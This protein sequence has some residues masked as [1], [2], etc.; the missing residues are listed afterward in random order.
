ML[1]G[2]AEIFGLTPERLF[3]LAVAESNL[4]RDLEADQRPFSFEQ[5]QPPVET[6]SGI[7]GDAF[8]SYAPSWLESLPLAGSHNHEPTRSRNDSVTGASL[9]IDT[10]ALLATPQLGFTNDDHPFNFD[11]VQQTGARGGITGE[12]SQSFF[13]TSFPAPNLDLLSATSLGESAGSQ[14]ARTEPAPHPN[15]PWAGVIADEN[16]RATALT[17]YSA[18]P[19][20]QS[21]FDRELLPSFREPIPAPPPFNFATGPTQGIEPRLPMAPTT[22]GP[23]LPPKPA[24][25]PRHGRGPVRDENERKQIEDTRKKG[26]CIPCSLHRIKVRNS[27]SLLAA[28]HVCSVFLTR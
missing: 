14:I 12:T 10:Q 18:N 20:H 26:A 4:H 1:A 16:Y 17:N 2:T 6:T 9:D 25:R 7:V 22:H 21:T 11:E 27:Q 19:P 15:I 8:G 28:T 24:K 5:S 23:E 13:G 3:A